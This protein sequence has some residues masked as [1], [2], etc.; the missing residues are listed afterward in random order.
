[1]KN[2][3]R[4]NHRFGVR[5]Q[6]TGSDCQPRLVR[7]LFPVD[8]R[9]AICAAKW[10]AEEKRFQKISNL[11]ER[12]GHDVM[13][14]KHNL[15]TAGIPMDS[16]QRKFGIS[17]DDFKLAQEIGITTLYGILLFPKRKR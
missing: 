3:G 12:I 5:Q 17:Q 10:A 11:M 15:D 14:F 6:K 4:S 2:K 1:M 8:P 13:C 7:N 9:H 16:E